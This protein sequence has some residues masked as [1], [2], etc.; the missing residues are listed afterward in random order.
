MDTVRNIPTYLDDIKTPCVPLRKTILQ[1]M[2]DCGFPAAEIAAVAE[3]MLANENNSQEILLAQRAKNRARQR[4]WE[5]KKKLTL[6][7]VIN[8]KSEQNQHQSNVSLTLEENQ[9]IYVEAMHVEPMEP[10]V[11]QVMVKPSY[12]KSGAREAELENDFQVFWEAYPRSEGRQAAIKA[13]QKARKQGVTSEEILAGVSRLTAAHGPDYGF[14][15]H[16]SAWLNGKRWEDKIQPRD[17]QNGRGRQGN[18]IPAADRLVE[19]LKRFERGESG[20]L[21]RGGTGSAHVRML[22]ER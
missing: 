19:N 7:N 13:Y 3:A 15:Q 16:G 10:I 21:I 22:S 1:R 20:G 2:I 18:I 4:K 8:E 9:G 14:Y 11:N 12:S 6:D 17:Q 5:A